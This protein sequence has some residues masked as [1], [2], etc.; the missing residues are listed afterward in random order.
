MVSAGDKC[1][2][3]Q[4]GSNATDTHS[5]GAM[6]AGM[7]T[8]STISR[9]YGPHMPLQWHPPF[10]LSGWQSG[11]SGHRG[12]KPFPVCATSLR[13]IGFIDHMLP[14]GTV[15]APEEAKTTKSAREGR[16][17]HDAWVEAQAATSAGKG[18]K[19]RDTW[20][21]AEGYATHL[22]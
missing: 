22:R 9:L 18:R 19:H 21:A 14:S 4:S 1:S 11:T 7:A 20:V 13:G 6:S 12:E 16:K 2:R 15:P 3:P 5:P 8:I 17:H 10:I